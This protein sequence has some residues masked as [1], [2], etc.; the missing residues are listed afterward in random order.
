M[1]DTTIKQETKIAKIEADKVVA[2]VKTVK[3]KN[4]EDLDAA[5][6][7][8]T[9]IKTVAK[10]IANKKDSIIRPLNQS[11]REI[12]ELFAEPEKHLSEA[13]KQLKQAILDYQAKVEKKAEKKAAKIEQKNVEGK[14]G[15]NEAVNELSKVE[16]LNGKVETAGG[17][18]QFR[19]IKKVRI[20]NIAEIPA[21]YFADPKVMDA[22]RVAVSKDALAG[23]VIP[24]VEV[25]EEKQVAGG[26]NG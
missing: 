15:L 22:L 4:A 12:R 26:T 16:R 3:I 13:E 25:Y 8:L 18:V 9:K 24:G 10:G 1:P 17:A 20:V 14:I 5:I 21:R 2:Q 11:I 6:S 19:V 23:E 7:L